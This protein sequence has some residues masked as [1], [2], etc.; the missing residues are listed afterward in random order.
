MRWVSLYS[1][2]RANRSRNSTTSFSVSLLHNLE[3]QRR[4]G[5]HMGQNTACTQSHMG[6]RTFSWS[7][8]ECTPSAPTPTCAPHP[9][10]WCGKH[11]T[12]ASSALASLPPSPHNTAHHTSAHAHPYVPTPLSSRTRLCLTPLP[13]LHQVRLQVGE[14]APERARRAPLGHARA[15]HGRR[16]AQLGRRPAPHGPLAPVAPVRCRRH[17]RDDRHAL[18]RA[19][20]TWQRSL[21]LLRVALR[22]RRVLLF[23]ATAAD[24][25]RVF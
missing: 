8:L 10:Q 14:A 2:M 7:I 13:L 19:L 6:L 9:W 22:M 12:W 17:I 18:R 5:S 16:R 15:A 1:L 25:A 11:S 23:T 3:K 4:K 20:S 24:A 21:Q